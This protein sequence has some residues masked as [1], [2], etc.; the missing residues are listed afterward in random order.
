MKLRRKSPSRHCR[1]KCRKHLPQR[2]VAQRSPKWNHSKSR[3]SSSHMRQQ[4]L[5]EQRR[6]R[7]RGVPTVAN[8]LTRSEQGG[9]FWS[10]ATLSDLSSRLSDVTGG[11]Q[12][13]TVLF[14]A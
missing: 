4:R 11:G 9:P 13:V 5:R 1:R 8:S 7:S 14:L 3:T 2:L 6:A 10:T 12:N